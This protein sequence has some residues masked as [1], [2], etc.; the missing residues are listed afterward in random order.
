MRPESLTNDPAISQEQ[1]HAALQKLPEAYRVPLL[2]HYMEGRTEAETAA[3]MGCKES[4]ASMRLTRG[5]QMLR[6]RLAKQGVAISLAAM[7]AVITSNASA[8]VPTVT[9]RLHI[10]MNSG[11]RSCRAP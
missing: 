11:S 6:E 3:L 10:G 7:T 2:L 4:T 9:T 1:L 5:R 8:N